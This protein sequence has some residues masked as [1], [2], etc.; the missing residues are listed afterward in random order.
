M[1]APGYGLLSGS[2]GSIFF[3]LEL[4]MTPSLTCNLMKTTLECGKQKLKD[5][6]VKMLVSRLVI[7]LE[8]PLL[9]V[10]DPDNEILTKS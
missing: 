4:R 2:D 9:L 5:K 10:T 7:G 3:R 6:I 8:F 1:L